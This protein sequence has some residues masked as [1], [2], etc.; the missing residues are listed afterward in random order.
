MNP[1]VV[2]EAEQQ[3]EHREGPGHRL[4]TARRAQN[5]DL[6][7]VAVQ[8]HLSS[9]T[10]AFLEQDR[11]DQLPGPVFV[12][13]YIRNYARL[14]GLAD[15][16]LLQAY[17]DSLP[18]DGVEPALG[19]TVRVKQGV[20]SS[21]LAV[22]LV[23]LLLIA[24]LVTLVVLWGKNRLGPPAGLERQTSAA[25]PETPYLVAESAS[26]PLTGQEPATGSPET[27][28]QAD[29]G[30][31][32]GG[33]F[34]APET[35]VA[36]LSSPEELP[37]TEADAVAA[38]VDGVEPTEQPRAEPDANT[39]GPRSADWVAPES[40]AQADVT[41]LGAVAEVP[42]G[43]PV[44]LEF[45]DRCWVNIRDANGQNRV[46]GELKAGDRRRLEGE[47]PFNIVLGNSEAVRILVDGKPYDFSP[48][49]RGKVAR[50]K[51]DP[52]REAN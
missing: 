41:S 31:H 50:F 34:D 8:L 29:H 16:P 2:E 20:G 22:K 36:N 47:P 32:F 13:G 46:L 43:P 14:V 4:R 5:L 11:Y 35:P 30:V 49:L 42:P 28:P 25:D 44:V 9:V 24:G 26:D 40:T 1:G 19:S 39:A 10:V 51:L 52:S 23:T 17:R 38:A 6:A 21:H 3:L 45:S 7:Q 27:T 12:R 37:G 15:E 33:G 18:E 48:Y